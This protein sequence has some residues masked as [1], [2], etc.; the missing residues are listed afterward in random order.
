MSVKYLVGMKLMMYF[1]IWPLIINKNKI[2]NNRKEELAPIEATEIR[3][4]IHYFT[5]SPLIL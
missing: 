4:K 1:P 2:K 5:T 3:K